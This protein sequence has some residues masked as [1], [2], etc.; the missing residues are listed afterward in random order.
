MKVDKEIEEPRKKR[1]FMMQ[2]ICNECKKSHR[3][4]KLDT[5][6]MGRLHCTHCKS[7]TF[8]I[9]KQFVTEDRFHNL[10]GK[11]RIVMQEITRIKYH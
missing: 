2:F 5:D 11:D 9:K 6:F 3:L 7:K 1:Y 8:E 4:H 10:C